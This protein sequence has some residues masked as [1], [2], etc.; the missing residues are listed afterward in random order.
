MRLGNFFQT[1]TE[2]VSD[3]PTTE[4]AAV[5]FKWE[6][7]YNQTVG[8]NKTEFISH[9]KSQLASEMGV[10]EDRITNLDVTE[11]E[12]NIFFPLEKNN[13]GQLCISSLV[14]LYINI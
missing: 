6:G 14:S 9:V 2:A 10:D 7:S 11:G 8:D 1:Q 12:L 5:E 3:A 4:S 13:I